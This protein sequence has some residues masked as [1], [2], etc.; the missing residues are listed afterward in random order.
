MRISDWSSDVCS[1][2]LGLPRSGGAVGRGAARPDIRATTSRTSARCG[3]HMLDRSGPAADAGAAESGSDREA[4]G[5]ESCRE[6]V[7]QY[8]SIS[9]VAVALK[10][11]ETSITQSRTHSHLNI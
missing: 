1:S 10:Q 7:C 3:S 5:R 2:D 6:R 4:I 9:V 11:K 8:V